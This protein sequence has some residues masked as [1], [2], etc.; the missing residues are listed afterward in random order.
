[1]ASWAGEA[2]R[3]RR[4]DIDMAGPIWIYRP[5]KHK[6]AWR[7]QNRVIALGPKSQAILKPFLKPELEAYL[8]SPRDGLESFWESQRANRQTKVYPYEATKKT[9]RKRK[10]RLE[11]LREF[12]A[13]ERL[14]IAIGKAC[15]RAK[16]AHWSANQLRHLHGTEIRRHYGLEGAQTA[17]GHLRI[18]TTQI[19]AEKDSELAKKI[20]AEVG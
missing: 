19:Y 3:M 10:K 13:T 9:E 5:K 2:C 7:G 16:V 20:A 8:F 18:E 14:D 15:I 6:N 4:V 1:M 17:L 12:Y 11:G